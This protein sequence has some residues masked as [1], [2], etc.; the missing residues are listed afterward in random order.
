MSWSFG[1]AT[2]VTDAVGPARTLQACSDYGVG[3]IR[4]AQ[5]N[6]AIQSPNSRPYNK[7]YVKTFLDAGYKVVYDCNHATMG[8]I[9]RSHLASVLARCHDVIDT[10]GAYT[11]QMVLEAINECTL[12][13][14]EHTAF[15]QDIVD[16]LREYGWKGWIHDDLVTSYQV[17]DAPL[18]I[19]DPLNLFCGGWHWYAQSATSLTNILQRIHRY[20]DAGQW[21]L[22]TEFG[23]AYNNSGPEY[24]KYTSTNV[25]LISQLFQACKDLGKF[26][27]GPAV[28]RWRTVPFLW[29]NHDTDDLR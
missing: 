9:Q 27:S 8:T 11:E 25:G 15:M 22:N 1:F 6:N 28:G 21:S 19:H 12:S 29:M 23:A 18:L 3:C 26:P 14:A 13:V 16:D 20:V 2:T 5:S 4:L 7:N 24:D 10:F 17:S